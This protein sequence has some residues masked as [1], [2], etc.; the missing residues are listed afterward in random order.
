MAS[1]S[2]EDQVGPVLLEDVDRLKQV[3][4]PTGGGLVQIQQMAPGN[5]RIMARNI[6]GDIYVQRQKILLSNV[7]PYVGN[8]GQNVEGE[9]PIGG[10]FNYRLKVGKLCKLRMKFTWRLRTVSSQATLTRAEGRG[11]NIMPYHLKLRGGPQASN[12]TFIGRTV[13]GGNPGRSQQVH[14][15]SQGCTGIGG[16]CRT[17][18]SLTEWDVRSTSA[19]TEQQLPAAGTHSITPGLSS[20]MHPS[21]ICP[22]TPVCLSISLSISPRCYCNWD[23]AS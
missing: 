19:N 4:R 13:L 10:R 18:A 5:V 2:D 9:V 3:P 8:G 17:K 16:H 20:K 6:P 7:T 21:C 14:N 23:F 11:A 1:A 15:D 22:T 12:R